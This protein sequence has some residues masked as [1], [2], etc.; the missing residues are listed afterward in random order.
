MTLVRTEVLVQIRC[1][2]E[3]ALL[4][5]VPP[6]FRYR[7]LH[8]GQLCCKSRHGALLI[9]CQLHVR[10]ADLCET[11]TLVELYTDDA[12]KKNIAP[13]LLHFSLLS[14]PNNI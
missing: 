13:L 2:A 1:A 11:A 8:C 14:F 10:T 5:A 3:L 12:R 9:R 4:A 7:Q 6:S